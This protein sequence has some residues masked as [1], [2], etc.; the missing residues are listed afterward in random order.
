MIRSKKEKLFYFLSITLITI[1]GLG[2]NSKSVNAQEKNDTTRSESAL[3]TFPVRVIKAQKRLF[4]RTV[5]A[6]G[7]IDTKEHAIVSAR[8]GGVLT[9]LFVDEGD[10]V[11]ANQTPLFQVDK[12]N[13]EQAVEISKQDLAVA[14]SAILEADANLANMQAQFDKAKVDYERFQRLLEKKAVSK[15]AY[16]LQE[17]RYKAAKA[18]LD[19]ALAVCQLSKEQLKKAEHALKIAEK[20]LSDSLVYAPISGSVSYKFVEQNEYVSGGKPIV[21]I[22][23]PDVMEMSVFLPSDYYPYIKVNETK[24]R[25]STLTSEIGTVTVTYKSPTILPNLRTF[26]VK[27]IIDKENEYA[28]AGAMVQVS[29]ILEERENIGILKQCVMTQIDKKYL[30]KVVDNKAVMAVVN[31]GFETEG[32]I[33]ITEGDL[34]EGDEVISMGQTFI[35]EGQPVQIL[36]EN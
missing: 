35:K 3:Q 7:S 21:K 26:E 14:K 32:W 34:K 19:H 9:D 25:I 12:A 17:T 8:I 5:D 2:C 1:V 23:N 36:E 13:V 27:A 6:Q 31:T 4:L 20:N 18:G 15:D 29:A 22:D 28:V 33:E 24:L 11:V 10:V 16:E 30:F